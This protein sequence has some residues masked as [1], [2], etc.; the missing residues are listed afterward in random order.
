[1]NVRK[2]GS[3]IPISGEI[4][5]EHRS[6]HDDRFA[7]RIES[8]TRT[9]PTEAD[10]AEYREGLALLE[11]LRGNRFYEEGGPDEGSTIRVPE[12][13]ITYVYAETHDEWLCRVRELMKEDQ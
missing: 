13:T 7:R 5:A 12:D 1:M 2:Y 8:E 6:W 3:S 9:P 4:Y 11:Q 10:W